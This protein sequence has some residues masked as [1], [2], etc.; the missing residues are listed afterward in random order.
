MAKELFI[1]HTYKNKDKEVIE[2]KYRVDADFVPTQQ[3]EI[4][5]EFIKNYCISKGKEDVKWLIDLMTTNVE[6]NSEKKKARK[7][8]NL[9][10]RKQFV[11]KYFPSL[12]GIKATDKTQS[13]LDELQSFLNS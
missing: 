3:N 2:T 8:T 5:I 12:V 10:I 1:T 9:E 7:I 6:T 13:I 11:N 4:C